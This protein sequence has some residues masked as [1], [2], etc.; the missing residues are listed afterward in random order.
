[1]VPS[2]SFLLAISIVSA[3]VR[4]PGDWPLS[5]DRFDDLSMAIADAG[6][7]AI[8]Y[9]RRGFGRSDQPWTGYDYDT[10]ADNLAAVLEQCGAKDATSFVG[11]GLVVGQRR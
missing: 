6:M 2:I 11:S 3:R 4:P 10:L 7:R 9:D 8:S 5:S 1:M